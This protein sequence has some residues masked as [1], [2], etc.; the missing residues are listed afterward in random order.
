MKRKQK[1]SMMNAV[2]IGFGSTLAS[3]VAESSGFVEV[4]SGFTGI[5]KDLKT[6]IKEIQARE[7]FFQNAKF[8]HMLYEDD[9]GY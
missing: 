6:A 9:Y 5:I 3:I 8:E 7:A 1:N 4:E 2:A